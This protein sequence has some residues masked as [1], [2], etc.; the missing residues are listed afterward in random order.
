M[1]LPVVLILLRS[2]PE[3]II[4]SA[5]SI[6][7]LPS[8]V[9]V[10]GVPIPIPTRDICLGISILLV[11]VISNISFNVYPFSSTG[12]VISITV[13]PVSI[14]AD[15]FSGNPPAAPLSLV[16]INLAPVCL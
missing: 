5:V 7:F 8:A 3:P 4:S 14:A 13:M 6:A 11:P 1:V 2:L 9:R 12:L 16:T 10:P 15:I